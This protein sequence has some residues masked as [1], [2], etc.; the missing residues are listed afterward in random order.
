MIEEIRGLYS[1][2]RR[3]HNMPE[4]SRNKGGKSN[5]G[6]T[7]YLPEYQNMTWQER[8]NK[9]ANNASD[10]GRCW[11]IFQHVVRTTMARKY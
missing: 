7:S 9:C 1:K 5:K 8:V 3:Y 10:N 4:V 6:N 2:E 11:W